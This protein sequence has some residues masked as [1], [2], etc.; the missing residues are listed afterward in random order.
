MN[1]VVIA[2]HVGMVEDRRV[3]V[4]DHGGGIWDHVGR[5]GEDVGMVVDHFDVAYVSSRSS[6]VHLI[7]ALDIAVTVAADGQ[8][9]RLGPGSRQ[10]RVLSRGRH[11]L[12]AKDERGAT[13]EEQDLDVPGGDALVAYN[14]LGAG[15]LIAREVFYTQREKAPDGLGREIFI[16][17]RILVKENVTYPFVDIPEKIP[18]SADLRTWQVTQLPGGWRGALGALRE[19]GERLDALALVEA[20]SVAEPEDPD[21]V[22]IAADTIAEHAGVD[23]AREHLKRLAARAPGSAAVRAAEDSLRRRGTP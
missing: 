23:A 4:W 18:G 6:K 5:I 7:N 20:V 2:E 16:G 21:A 10:V 12:V 15:P 3:D 22:R 9:V 17:H 19:R 13:L 8:A 14:V 1:V 11:H